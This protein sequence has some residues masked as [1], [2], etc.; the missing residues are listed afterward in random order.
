[1]NDLRPVNAS[2]PLNDLAGPTEPIPNEVRIQASTENLGALRS[3]HRPDTFLA[4]I[5]LKQARVYLFER[6]ILLS[7]G[8]G[9]LG[10]Y[11][12]DQVAA[13]R[14]GSALFVHRADGVDL[15]LTRH[16]SEAEALAGAVEQGVAAAAAERG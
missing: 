3:V 13:T 10:L 8:R 1:M 14:Q 16:W 7:N 15:R 6:G 12:W 5:A 9:G 11:R 4:R 2:K